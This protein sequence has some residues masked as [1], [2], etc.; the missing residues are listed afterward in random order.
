MRRI[1]LCALMLYAAGAQAQFNR[2]YSGDA[3]Q[4]DQAVSAY[5][6]A[7][8]IKGFSVAAVKNGNIVY[9]K[10]YGKSDVANNINADECTL[11][12]IG[13]MSKFIT[14]V[15][16][17]QLFE[18]GYMSPDD[19]IRTYVPEFPDKGKTITVGDLLSHT[20][21]IQD[22]S[23]T[24]TSYMNAN[25]SYNPI[26]ALDIFKDQPLLGSC[27]VGGSI[28][29]YSNWGYDLLGAVIERAGG[30]PYEAQLYNRIIKPLNLEML[31]P[32]YFW[33]V[34]LKTNPDKRRSNLSHRFNIC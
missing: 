16:A 2:L 23:S 19:D 26:A 24:N 20:G 27:T 8:N 32:E 33:S 21:C 6:S 12:R 34:R 14:S 18:M 11:Y 22:N 29:N 3:S 1:I 31:Q 28:G 5:M 10:G 25:L 13:S 7:N 15:L 17:N 30:E 4:I 9:I